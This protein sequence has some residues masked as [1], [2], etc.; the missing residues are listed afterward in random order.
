MIEKLNCDWLLLGGTGAKARA[1]QQVL[2][3]GTLEW[4]S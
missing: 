4:N 2:G 1:I 3:F